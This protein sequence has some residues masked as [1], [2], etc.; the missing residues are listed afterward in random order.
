MWLEYFKF[1]LISN[2]SI[3]FKHIFSDIEISSSRLSLYK[4]FTYMRRV[5][6]S[7]IWN[8]QTIVFL[9]PKLIL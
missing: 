4:I 2:Y 5:S 9:L 3:I 7:I 8:G 6:V 1:S